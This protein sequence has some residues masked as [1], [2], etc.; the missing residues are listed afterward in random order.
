MLITHLF[1]SV[2]FKIIE[3]LQFTSGSDDCLDWLLWYVFF[4]RKWKRKRIV[5]GTFKI[6][7]L[8]K[9]DRNL[10]PPMFLYH[11]PVE[12]NDNV[13][14]SVSMSKNLN[15]RAT[16]QTITWLMITSALIFT[17]VQQ[18]NDATFEN[19]HFRIQKLE[20]KKSF[21][22]CLLLT[23]EKRYNHITSRSDRHMSSKWA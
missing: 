15:I 13:S 18:N 10:H 19:R 1:H 21:T 8:D 22:S 3:Y 6:L 17:H 2:S 20:A 14:K 16:K 5:D 12:H 11:F 9:N 4:K 23:Y 7:P